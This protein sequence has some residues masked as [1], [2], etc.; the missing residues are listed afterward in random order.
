MFEWFT[1]KGD[2]IFWSDI[3]N[4]INYVVNHDDEHHIV[5]GSDSQPT[6]NKTLYVVAVCIISNL[7]QYERLYFY[8]KQ[9][10]N[11][12]GN[13]YARVFQETNYATQ[14]ALSLKDYSATLELNMNVSIHLDL[15]PPTKK[16]KT[17]KYSTGLTAFVKSCGF[18]NVDIKPSSW[19]SSSIADRYTKKHVNYSRNSK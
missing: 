1:A 8:G 4:K 13:L 7:P 10:L 19:A 9:A 2:H 15:S 5:V 17:S 14:V 12:P 11:N 6:S 3:C 18:L 16:N